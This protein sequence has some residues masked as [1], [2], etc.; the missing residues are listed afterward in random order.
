MSTAVLPGVLESFCGKWLWNKCGQA[1]RLWAAA[2]F[3]TLTAVGLSFLHVLFNLSRFPWITTLSWFYATLRWTAPSLCRLADA[4][5]RNQPASAAAHAPEWRMLG[6][7][8]G[9]FAR[10][11]CSQRTT[12][13]VIHIHLQSHLKCQDKSCSSSHT[14]HK[15]KTALSLHVLS[16]FLCYRCNVAVIFM[17]EM[18]V[19]HG[20]REDWTMHLPLLLHALFLGEVIHLND[21]WTLKPTRYPCLAVPSSIF[22]CSRLYWGTKINVWSWERNSRKNKR[23]WY[24]LWFLLQV[25][26]TTVQRFSNTASVFF[27]TCS[28]HCH[29]ITTSR[30]SPPS[31]CRHVRS[32][33]QRPWPAS[34]FLSWTTYP[35]VT[36]SVQCSRCRLF[37]P[38]QH[39]H[40]IILFGGDVFL[41]SAEHV[42]SPSQKQYWAQRTSEVMIKAFHS[43]I[44]NLLL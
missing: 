23:P 18:V 21:V 25:W 4:C 41:I 5:D 17:T 1:Q 22:I 38:L 31:C 12:A 14:S 29:A 44:F 11:G 43:A 13:S 26:I 30:P 32:M 3:S 10:D 8:G 15:T 37:S 42:W 28:S 9:L 27:S 35:Q 7:T 2:I 34:Q 16:L 6:S 24:K 36:I 19:D 20:V 40:G 39:K 33:A